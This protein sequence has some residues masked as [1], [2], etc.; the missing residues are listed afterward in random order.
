MRKIIEL[1]S[2]GLILSLLGA[3]LSFGSGISSISKYNPSAVAITGGTING[4][5][6]GATSEASGKFTTVQSTIATGTAPL[7]VTSTTNV[8]NL[9]AALL[10]G[11][12]FASPAS[13][14]NTTPD[15]G[16]FTTLTANYFGLNNNLLISTTSP[17][18]SSGFGTTP[19]ISSPNGNATFRV[20]VG[21]G[22][23]ASAGVVALE[24]IGT[25]W[26]CTVEKI[27]FTTNTKTIQTASTATT[28]TVTNYT[29]S[30]G[31][32]AAWP[33]SSILIFMCM[34]F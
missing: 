20:N 27:G 10:N 15:T 26:N 32:V 21:T 4:A 23:T 12:T 17:T 25:G 13:I 31:A 1:F 22:G 7:I 34:A 29:I 6:V 28:V 16:K 14:G 8:A 11:K 5:T 30:T 18:I 2:I 19:S 24:G 33:A 3:T 9:N